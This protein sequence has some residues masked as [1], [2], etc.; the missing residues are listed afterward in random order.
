MKFYKTINETMKKITKQRLDQLI[1]NSHVSKRT[2]KFTERFELIK[3]FFLE[4]RKRKPPKK[5]VFIKTSVNNTIISTLNFKK[6]HI[7]SCGH[8]GF[9][10]AKRGST[11]AAQKLGEEIGRLIY[12]QKEHQNV[13][14]ILRGIK[15]G[16]RNTIQGLKKKLKI[17]KVI[18]KTSPSHNGCRP[19]KKKRR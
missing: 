2:E 7:L 10:G 18:D 8:L 14:V 3:E 11:Y 9:E 1:K 17:R 13:I 6:N 16:K 15:K 12:A 5:K 4:R 19:R